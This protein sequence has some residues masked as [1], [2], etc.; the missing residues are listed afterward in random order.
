MEKH[1]TIE[2]LEAYAAHKPDLK[3]VLKE[4]L[5]QAFCDTPTGLRPLNLDN[6]VY[7]VKA[8]DQ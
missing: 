6:V 2:A 8:N 4:C 7:L 5:R 3:K 1:P